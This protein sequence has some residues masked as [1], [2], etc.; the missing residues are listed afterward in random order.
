MLEKPYYIRGMKTRDQE[1]TAAITRRVVE[2]FARYSRHN[3]RRRL[4]RELAEL[5]DAVK[6]EP[7]VLLLD[8]GFTKAVV[9]K[10]I[11]IKAEWDRA[12]R[13]G[14]QALLLPHVFAAISPRLYFNAL[15]DHLGAPED[16]EA[17]DWLREWS[18]SH[19]QDILLAFM[20][21]WLEDL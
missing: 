14:R 7:G 8:L 13:R 18:S 17:Y 15:I 4:S 2:I 19:E 6:A 10:A 20:L 21:N 3:S 9:H 1:H 12:P 16:E 5:M 11:A